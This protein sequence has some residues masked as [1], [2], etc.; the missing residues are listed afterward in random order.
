MTAE[1]R[2]RQL[3]AAEP[4]FVPFFGANPFR[5]FHLQLPPSY[6]RQELTHACAR[7][8]Q[9]DAGYL[10]TQEA[11]VGLIKPRFQIEVL[12]PNV[13]QVDQAID[14][15]IAWLRTV[16]FANNDQFTSPPTTPRQ[17]PN[18]VLNVRPG[19]EPRLKP[20]VPTKMVDFKIW[21]LGLS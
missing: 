7:V 19:M 1:A 9:V 10:Y 21:N 2:I 12:S 5:W 18:F 15:I 17:F 16:C 8:T 4:T 13:D 3:A 11:Q 20:P 6:F 14:A